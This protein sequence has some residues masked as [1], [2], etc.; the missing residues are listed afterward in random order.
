M[1]FHNNCCAA[2]RVRDK[3]RE[4][5]NQLLQEASQTRGKQHASLVRAA[6]ALPA[7]MP[8][9]LGRLVTYLLRVQR[10]VPVNIT[11]NRF[12]FSD[13]YTL[14]Q[15]HPFL[16]SAQ[17]AS[18]LM[19]LVEVGFGGRTY[20]AIGAEAESLAKRITPV[21]SQH[22][23]PAA[24]GRGSRKRRGHGH[25]H[26]NDDD[27]NESVLRPHQCSITGLIGRP[28]SV[29][30]AVLAEEVFK[31]L[32][33]WRILAYVE[34][35]IKLSL[36]YPE[37]ALISLMKH[38]EWSTL[39]LEERVQQHY[40]WN[41]SHAENMCS[42]V[43]WSSLR[44]E[45]ERD[46]QQGV[47]ETNKGA[48]PS[49]TAK[50]SVDNFLCAGEQVHVYEPERCVPAYLTA[51][52]SSRA[53]ACREPY[54]H[55]TIDEAEERA[56][57]WP[58]SMF[59][60]PVKCGTRILI[61]PLYVKGEVLDLRAD[62]SKKYL[63]PDHHRGYVDVLWRTP[64]TTQKFRVNV[65]ALMEMLNK[66]MFAVDQKSTMTLVVERM[67][68]TSYSLPVY[69]K[70]SLVAAAFVTKLLVAQS[71]EVQD[72]LGE[73]LAPVAGTAFSVT[74][75]TNIAY[76]RIASQMEYA[77]ARYGIT[78]TVIGATLLTIMVWLL[79]GY[80]LL[81]GIGPTC[82]ALRISFTLY[83][84]DSEQNSRA[85]T[86]VKYAYSSV[87]PTPSSADSNDS[88]PVKTPLSIPGPKS[89]TEA[90]SSPPNAAN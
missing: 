29:F 37:G 39:P 65:T 23:A 49:S 82:V 12:K 36:G 48:A 11:T 14:Y 19:A 77:S 90:K 89:A 41:M 67:N 78:A 83:N 31:Y 64:A 32:F 86:N 35:A 25:R 17:L 50:I 73:E 62:S 15:E 33:G 13:L 85:P 1:Q 59:C 53:V 42:L 26:E 84:T 56:L 69:S 7:K 52:F 72:L 79:L 74:E 57:A 9:H 80:S 44:S 6:N 43:D 46:Y 75:S 22:T 88:S 10:G 38:R 4:L 21:L 3:N 61:V 27:F 70:D 87:T 40:C 18:Q 68:R 30:S 34:A 45:W 55:Y 5:K 76:S 81:L 60:L 47:A 20:V 58:F 24:S 28:T 71:A 54:L 66:P 16:I 63:A 8:V 51:L 2:R